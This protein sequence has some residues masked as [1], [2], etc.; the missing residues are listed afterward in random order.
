M[1]RRIH[2]NFPKTE[3]KVKVTMKN[4]DESFAVIMRKDVHIIH[5]MKKDF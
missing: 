5:L 2:L 1:Y 3:S 4:Y